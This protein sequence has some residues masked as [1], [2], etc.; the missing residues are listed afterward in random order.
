MSD[1]MNITAPWPCNIGVPPDGDPKV[2][3]IGGLLFPVAGVGTHVNLREEA[4]RNMITN[5]QS[6]YIDNDSDARITVEL[7]HASR[8]RV[9]GK[10]RTQ[11]WYPIAMMDEYGLIFTASAIVADPLA[12]R[13]GFANINLMFGPYGI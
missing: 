10:A 12:V 2:L 6:V 7:A 4:Q 11:G 5:V 9:I 13:I 1:L 3:I 8:H